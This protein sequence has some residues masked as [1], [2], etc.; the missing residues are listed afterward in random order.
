MRRLIVLLGGDEPTRAPLVAELSGAGFIAL[1]RDQISELPTDAA[2]V[3]VVGAA[4]GSRRDGPGGLLDL[5]AAAR[6]VLQSAVIIA[7]IPRDGGVSTED[8]IKGSIQSGA[9]DI[10]ICPATPGTCAARLNASAR[11]AEARESIE[12]MDRYGGALGFIARGLEEPSGFGGADGLPEILAQVS[13]AI[14]WSRGA[15][16]VNSDH[17]DEII[18]VAASDARD[19]VRATL[20]LERYPEV[21]ACLASRQP[22]FVDDTRTSTLLGLH[23][24]TAAMHG[25]LALLAVPVVAER[26][27][28]GVMLLRSVTAHPSF[29]GQALRFAQLAGVL[30]GLVL[31]SDGVLDGLRDQTRRYT[32]QDFALERRSRALEQYRDFFESASDGMVVVDLSGA[33][34]YLNRA[35]E[36]LSGYARE[37]LIGRALVEVV[38]AEQREFLLQQIRQTT[39]GVDLEVFDIQLIT[40]SREPITVS[41]S[42]SAVLSE[43][44]AAVLAFRDVTEARSLEAELQ[45]TK[46]FLERLIDSTVDG[47]IAADLEGQVMIFNQGAARLYGYAPEEVIGR[48]T[49][50]QLYPEGVARQ[51]MSELRADDRGGVGRLEPSRREILTKDNE[52]VPVTLAAS[53]VYEDGREVASVGIVSDLRERIKIEERLQQAQ[54]KLLL[55]EKQALIAELAG[56]TAHE[57]NQPLTSVM[58]YAELLR[59]KLQPEDNNFRAIDIILREAERMAEI[60]RKIGRITRYETK[61][62]VGS[63]TILDLDKSINASEPTP[64]VNAEPESSADG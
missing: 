55:T 28:V 40:T 21:R 11:L 18:L 10:L 1:C 17:A 5:I 50:S 47:I 45:K 58:G 39:E 54:E 24:E 13:E 20:S 37:G 43:H 41:M 16:L 29:D 53:I 64:P 49:V 26:D 2:L 35:A 33:V 19:L 48:I 15:L 52:R 62:Y 57:L 27:V 42:L 4:P 8:G 36:Q 46:D 3:L 38:A 6:K 56:T 12:R 31:K 30:L 9:D 32:L 61:T 7:C 63:T 14:G 22:V 51:I 44:G 60:V 34:L 23:A 25:G 59:R